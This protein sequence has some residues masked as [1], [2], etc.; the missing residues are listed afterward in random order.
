M[1]VVNRR[2]FLTDPT[3]LPA[4]AES[5]VLE[6]A[7]WP[8]VGDGTDRPTIAAG[9]VYQLDDGRVE[10][11]PWLNQD[12]E[13]T[14]VALTATARDEVFVPAGLKVVST[15]D[16]VNGNTFTIPA[17]FGEDVEPGDIY[18]V[19]N[20][21]NVGDRLGDRVG[22]MATVT[23]VERSSAT[24]VTRHAWAPPQAGDVVMLVQSQIEYTP[25]ETTLYFALLDPD[26]EDTGQLSPLA[27][28]V[29]QVLA[30]FGI[31]NILFATLPRWLDPEPAGAAQIAET[32]I[33]AA[34]EDN[35]A[36]GA[37]AFGRLDGDTLVFNAGSWGDPVGYG[38]L[39]GILPGGLRI[40]L[41]SDLETAAAQLA[42]SFIA[43][44]LA[45][46]GD[47][48]LAAY[49]LEVATRDPQMQADVRYHLR[50]HLSE[51][52]MT[53]GRPDEALRVLEHDVAVSRLA[54][55]TR[56]LLNALSVLTSTYHRLG[57]CDSAVEAARAFLAAAEGEIPLAAHAS[58]LSRLAFCLRDQDAEGAEEAA[59]QARAAARAAAETDGPNG[60]LAL[61]IR[62]AE[63][64]VEDL[65]AA[66]ARIA[67]RV[68]EM[69][70]EDQV[71][72]L[73]LQARAFA[74]AGDATEAQ[75]L[76]ARAV[77]VQEEHSLDEDENVTLLLAMTYL[78]TQSF[79]D[80][81]EWLTRAAA[82]ML[83]DADYGGAARFLL[84][85][86]RIDLSLLSV[87]GFQPT[88][89]FVS[90]I[91]RKLD[92]SCRLY[93]IMGN[94]R[95]A[96]ECMVSLAVLQTAMGQHEASVTNFDHA[97]FHLVRSGSLFS[98]I[99]ALETR[100]RQME[101]SGAPEAAA[102]FEALLQEVD[103]RAQID[104]RYPMD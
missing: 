47:H 91:E 97:I 63:G 10:L 41:E 69:E 25:A 30:E 17:G 66:A 20:A 101:S 100:A 31:S 85:S 23:Q 2:L 34:V 18:F 42:P 95:E 59:E 78:F 61:E 27:A 48:A 72:F 14:D 39:I 13:M 88:P 35:D 38:G 22:A 81:T 60:E 46:R 103:I 76:A 12:S 89:E 93:R 51:R 49:L 32:A 58:E 90:A 73:L 19:M 56:A 21:T 53:L 82:D 65:R 26:A 15:I 67:P 54:G 1:T 40:T 98:L 44:G 8:R 45:M 11:V 96:G 50:E 92:T 104:E 74:E 9:H 28:A 57:D 43:T 37:V 86:S 36:F 99:S 6:P 80:A 5:F 16:D 83:A 79:E 64:S 94:S 52:W 70:P 77:E 7:M 102:S 68:Q 87:D 55:D 75:M 24:L 3:A 33:E 29:P 71:D 62:L 4:D 84:Y